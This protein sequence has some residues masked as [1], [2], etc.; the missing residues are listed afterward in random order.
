MHSAED[1]VLGF[2]KGAQ[3]QPVDDLE[4]AGVIKENSLKI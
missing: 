1:I 4:E 2:Q 3:S